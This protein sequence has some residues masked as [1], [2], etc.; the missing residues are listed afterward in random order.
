MLIKV[1]S[2]KA[3]CPMCKQKDGDVTFVNGQYN[4]GNYHTSCIRKVIDNGKWLNDARY[5]YFIRILESGSFEEKKG[6]FKE[7]KVSYIDRLLNNLTPEELKIYVKANSAAKK[8]FEEALKLGDAKNL[9]AYVRESWNSCSREIKINFI[10]RTN[11][12]EFYDRRKQE[13]FYPP[14]EKTID[15]LRQ[16]LHGTWPLQ[17]SFKEDFENLVDVGLQTGTLKIDYLL[18]IQQFYFVTSDGLRL[19]A[20]HFLQIETELNLIEERTLNS[21]IGYKDFATL[22]V[23]IKEKLKEALLLSNEGERILSKSF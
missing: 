23:P 11:D 1:S 9:E 18:S 22:P 14:T 8:R 2:K 17:E 12:K 10:K 5:E 6:F 20:K 21:I 15:E 4:Y 13:L 16:I 7:K 19:G 3:S